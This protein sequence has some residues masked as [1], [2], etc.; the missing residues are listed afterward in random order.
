MPCRNSLDRPCP[1]RRKS[2]LTPST[3]T[4]RTHG[5]NG[6]LRRAGRP[7]RC[8]N[9][10]LSGCH[11]IPPSRPTRF[12]H[13]KRSSCC[14]P[15][16]PWTATNSGQTTSIACRH[17][18]PTTCGAPGSARCPTRTPCRSRGNGRDAWRHW[19]AR[20]AGFCPEAI[21][22]A[23]IFASSNPAEPAPPSWRCP[24]RSGARARSIMPTSAGGRAGRRA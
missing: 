1:F 18:L 12:R 16:P 5:S 8:P 14:R 4:L 23:R 7:A 22:Q 19:I 21:D 9:Q 3:T 13:P 24:A 17:R 20:L 10:G 2:V 6:K 15:S 11:S